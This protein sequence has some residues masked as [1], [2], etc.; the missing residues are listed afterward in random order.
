[1][2]RLGPF[3]KPGAEEQLLFE[4]IF[5]SLGYRPHADTF[6]ALAQRY[7]LESLLP[8]LAHPAEDARV[9]LLARWF[10]ALGLLGDV[11]PEPSAAAEFATLRERW[12]SLGDAPSAG[13]VKR[14]GG[15]PLN[16]PERRMVGMLHHLANL[17]PR[18]LLRGWLAFLKQLDEQRDQP[19]FRRTA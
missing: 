12:L 2:Q 18:G 7:P 4:L 16:S 6:R 5:Q 8:H 15:R 9:E 3:W 13:P 11:A 19:E 14:G 1:A 10:G 17:G